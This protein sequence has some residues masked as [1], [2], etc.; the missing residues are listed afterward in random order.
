MDSWRIDL[1]ARHHSRLGVLAS[2][3]HW[4]RVPLAFGDAREKWRLSDFVCACGCVKEVVLETGAIA[5]RVDARSIG[6]AATT[7]SITL[8]LT[9]DGAPV[10]RTLLVTAAR[11][12][13]AIKVTPCVVPSLVHDESTDSS[14]K[15]AFV[16]VVVP[17]RGIIVGAHGHHG[18][19]VTEST[20]R[21]LQGGVAQ[22]FRIDWQ[23]RDGGVV[24]VV[25]DG[26]GLDHTVA[27]HLRNRLHAGAARPGVR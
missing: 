26:D 3:E 13:V 8:N 24:F 18:A 11:E 20:V 27:C 21:A 15:F 6:E 2:G 17:D 9:R 7:Q 12:R 19:V 10:V 5:L 23:E 14:R 25:R 22:R 1:E 4:F 16:E